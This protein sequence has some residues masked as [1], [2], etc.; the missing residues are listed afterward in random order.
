MNTRTTDQLA[1]LAN[2]QATDEVIVVEW[3]EL[4]EDPNPYIDLHLREA[5][6]REHAGK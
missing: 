5:W 1:N 4:G 6:Q 2:D 3:W